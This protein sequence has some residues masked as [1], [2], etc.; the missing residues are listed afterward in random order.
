MSLSKGAL[1]MEL[2][3]GFVSVEYV[4]VAGICLLAF[5][6]FGANFLMDETPRY[7]T[8]MNQLDDD[9]VVIHNPGALPNY[10]KATCFVMGFPS[11]ITS[12]DASCGQDVIIPA[13]IGEED[14]LYIGADAFRGKSLKSVIFPDNLLSI[15]DYAFRDNNLKNIVL[16]NSLVSIG[17]ESFMNNQIETMY[18]PN[19]ILSMGARAFNSNRLEEINAFIYE[20]GVG[21]IN[22]TKVV[23]YGGLDKTITVP[24]YV[25]T[26]GEGAFSFNGLE[27]LKLLVLIQTLESDAFANNNLKSVEF[28]GNLP[29][30]LGVDIFSGNV[31]LTS[32]TIRVPTPQIDAFREKA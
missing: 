25:T 24:Y 7:D 26:I 15:G 23:S 30:G 21:G 1:T 19:T 4:I 32:G 18:L 3:K 10:T 12:Y 11:T 13:V 6:V 31:D 17:V 28:E 2:K 16:P 20:Y 5:M 14:V 29:L 9:K 27:T 8:I 22:R